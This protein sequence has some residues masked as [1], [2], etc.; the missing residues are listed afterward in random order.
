MNRRAPQVRICRAI[1][2][3]AAMLCALFSGSLKAQADSDGAIRFRLGAGYSDNP[4]RELGDGEAAWYTAIGTEL[5]FDH[6]SR[7]FAASLLGDIEH[8][9]Y[10]ESD[11]DSEIYGELDATVVL[12]AVVDRF[13]WVFTNNY[14]QTRR[15]PFRIDSPLNRE[16]VNVF[17]TGPRISFPVGS[18]SMFRLLVLASDRSYEDS[19]IF[20][21]GART[22]QA[23]FR[24]ALSTRSA[25]GLTA[26][27]RTTEYDHLPF[28]ESEVRNFYATYE[29][30]LASGSAMAAAGVSRVQVG[31]RSD[32]APYFDLSWSRDVGARSHLTVSAGSEYV[33]SGH[34]FSS[35]APA[36]LRPDRVDDVLPSADVY[37]R[38]D[39][40]LSHVTRYA[41]TTFQIGAG[42]AR[43]RYETDV[44]LEHDERRFDARVSRQLSPRAEFGIG[45]RLARREFTRTGRQD[46]DMS[47]RLWWNKR[48]TGRLFV[49]LAF[50]RD[51]RESVAGDDYGE[52]SIRMLFA[53]DA[54]PRSGR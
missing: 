38:T 53:I 14:G 24:R 51:E 31:Q 30:R 50:R 7:R 5:A 32:S 13:A 11:I 49:E 8:R 21:G 46:D 25:L 39:A 10:S 22:V 17:S 27:D 3:L 45:A 4:L 36:G 29:S 1:P 34:D 26:V 47:A 33:D 20:D 28:R 19:S 48:L 2:A 40:A 16:Y 23:G 9:N 15:D 52:N 43:Q 54:R 42:L 44:G 12:Q 41:R 37:R 18:R 6:T 35:S